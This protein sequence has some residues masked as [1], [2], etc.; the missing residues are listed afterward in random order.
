VPALKGPALLVGPAH[1][2]TVRTRYF[3]GMYITREDLETDQR[4]VRLKRSLM[5]RAMGQGV[6]WGLDV[7]LDG[8][9]ICVLPG[10]G[11]DCCGNDVIVST[12]YRVDVDALLADPAAANACGQRGAHAM[13]LILEYY[14][15]PEEPRPVHGDPCSPDSTRCETSRVRETARLRLAVPGKLDDSGPLKDFLKPLE[16]LKNG[17]RISTTT[18]PA[19]QVPF[20]VLLEILDNNNVVA[21][22]SQ[23]TPS[24]SVPKTAYLAAF[25]NPDGGRYTA[26]VRITITPLPSFQFDAGSVVQ[27]KASE[28]AHTPDGPLPNENTT[29]PSRPFWWTNSTLLATM[30]LVDNGGPNQYELQAWK[31]H[32]QG[33]STFSAP[34]TEIDILVQTLGD[35]TAAHPGENPPTLDSSVFG[36]TRANFVVAVTVLATDVT[37]STSGDPVTTLLPCLTEGCDSKGSPLFPVTPPWLH[38]GD[39]KA[40]ALALVYALAVMKQAVRNGAKAT[41]NAG[42][43]DAKVTKDLYATVWRLMYPSVADRDREALASELQKLLQAWCRSLLYPGPNCPCEPHGVIIGCVRVEGGAIR[44]VDPWGG[45]RWVMH[46]PLL[47]YWGQQFGIMPF[48]AIASRL[49]HIICCVAHLARPDTR[50]SQNGSTYVRFGPESSMV[51]L[52]T[53]KL[54]VESPQNIG[55]RFASL[56]VAP[57]KSVTL[58]PLDFVTR[59]LALSSGPGG[60]GTKALVDYVP[61]GIANVHLLAPEDVGAT[62]T[63]AGPATGTLDRLIQ[64]SFLTAPKPPP[65]LRAFAASLV[66]HVLAITPLVASQEGNQKAVADAVARYGLTTIAALVD[67]EP[68]VLLKNVLGGANADAL[69]ALWGAAESTANAVAPTVADALGNY[70]QQSRITSRTDLADPKRAGEF[71][72]QLAQRL[73][74]AKV[75]IAADTLVQAITQAAAEN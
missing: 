28:H 44:Y 37:I 15:C 9:A 29:D 52:Q 24:T 67:R 1:G 50:E 54:L 30:N 35:W 53:A 56:G 40:L 64:A 66:R 39:P 12:P 25:A 55:K 41:V 31:V 20:S 3:N 22:S 74:A 59:L 42:T 8:N 68:E 21:G 2:G 72:N 61:L 63:P 16:T 11:V 18:A 45:R 23:I 46:Y 27:T 49:F 36:D 57:Q 60:T 43:P 38:S 73:K 5:N 65:V 62:P 75:D 19:S 34:F 58:Q 6:V 51:E 10:Y 13:N 71:G 32:D 4:N 26:R 70:A 7:C 17:T 14:E 48:D 69:N 33:S 47:A